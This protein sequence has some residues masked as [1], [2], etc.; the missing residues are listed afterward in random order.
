MGT[1]T[2]RYKFVFSEIDSQV[3]RDAV[4]FR[5]AAEQKKSAFWGRDIGLHGFL[6]HCKNLIESHNGDLPGLQT[7]E[8]GASDTGGSI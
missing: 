4:L 2:Q 5:L 7:D 1:P 6:K 3:F 8:Q